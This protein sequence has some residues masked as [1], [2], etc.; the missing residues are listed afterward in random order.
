[1]RQRAGDGGVADCGESLQS[2]RAQPIALA[3]GSGRLFLSL[4]SPSA[5]A[6]AAP[7]AAR[8]PRRRRGGP[9]PGALRDPRPR[10]PRPPPGGREGPGG[11]GGERDPRGEDTAVPGPAGNGSASEGATT[12]A[13]LWRGPDVNR[14][15]APEPGGSG[16]N[17]GMLGN[18]R[19]AR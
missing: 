11:V 15:L 14:R 18:K 4:Q 13:R 5:A 16:R 6:A 7:G 10:C 17:N 12:S 19:G 9:A 3:P 8:L 2:G 1:M